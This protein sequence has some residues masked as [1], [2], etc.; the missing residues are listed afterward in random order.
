[1]SGRPQVKL[2]IDLRNIEKFFPL[3]FNQE[4]GLDYEMYIDRERY[5]AVESTLREHGITGS[6]TILEFCFI[7]IWIEKYIGVY[8]E[9]ENLSGKFYQMWVELDHLKDYLLKHRI[10]SIVL[11]GENGRDMPG[12]NFTL[13]EEINIDRIC[14]SIRTAFREEFVNDKQSR[15]SKGAKNWKRRKM[16]KVKNYIMNYLTLIPEADSLSLEAQSHIIERLSYL[17]GV[18]T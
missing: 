15:R 8:D 4:G 9:R 17:A 1:M 10:T 13:K 6:G 11:K 18:S 2:A 12:K 5:D 14:D 7:V 3:E 16:V